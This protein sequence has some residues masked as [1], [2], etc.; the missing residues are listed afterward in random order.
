VGLVSDLVQIGIPARQAPFLGNTITSGAT[1]TGN[2][3]ATGYPIT[4]SIT[5]FTGGTL[6]VNFCATLPT[7]NEIA[8]S[9]LY[10]R[11]DSGIPMTVFPALTNSFNALAPNIGLGI[12]NNSGLIIVKRDESRSGWLTF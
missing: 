9:V 6:A 7:P 10:I 4:T 2:N 1:L 5:S 3:Q 12:A 11:N 8:E